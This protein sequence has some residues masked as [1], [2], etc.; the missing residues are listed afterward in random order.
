MKVGDLLSHRVLTFAR[1]WAQSPV[2][3]GWGSDCEQG[4]CNSSRTVTVSLSGTLGESSSKETNG[5]REG[6]SRKGRVKQRFHLLLETAPD[7]NGPQCG[8][9]SH[10]IDVEV[11]PPLRAP[12]SPVRFCLTPPGG[13]YCVRPGEGGK[14]VVQQTAAG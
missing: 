1:P 4:S 2:R 6:G 11:I 13:A 5:A 12:P 3:K 9:C 8:H 7:I 14:R 10:F